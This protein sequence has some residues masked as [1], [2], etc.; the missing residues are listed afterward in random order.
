MMMKLSTFLTIFFVAL[1]GGSDQISASDLLEKSDDAENTLQVTHIQFAPSPHG[2]FPVTVRAYLPEGQYLKQEL[3]AV[4]VLVKLDTPLIISKEDSQYR[5]GTPFSFVSHD[6]SLEERN[7][8]EVN[9]AILSEGLPEAGGGALE[10]SVNG[11]LWPLDLAGVKVSSTL[12]LIIKYC[13]E[14]SSYSFTSTF[15][16]QES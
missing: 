10:N 1:L 5:V 15:D 14:S 8:G 7:N 11:R 12:Y 2:I 6:G 13:P 16:I 9:I 3:R 4:S